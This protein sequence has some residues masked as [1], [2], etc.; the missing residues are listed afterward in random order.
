MEPYPKFRAGDKTVSFFFIRSAGAWFHALES[1]DPIFP[2]TQAVIVEIRKGLLGLFWGNPST[3]AGV[4]AC[5]DTFE[6][7]AD[8]KGNKCWDQ[9]RIHSALEVL[10]DDV[11]KQRVFYFVS[12]AL[13]NTYAWWMVHYLQ[14]SVLNATRQAARIVDIRLAEEQW[15]LEV[16]NIFN[17]SLAA[18]QL[19]AYD[20]ARGT[21]AP[22][23]NG[24][25]MIDNTPSIL[26]N[27]KSDV[28]VAV[29]ISKLFKFKN[30][31]Y[32]NISAFWFWTV[33]IGCLVI[34]LS[35]RRFSTKLTRHQ[36]TER[37]DDGGYHDCLWIT[38]FWKAICVVLVK[39]GKN[40]AIKGWN[41]AKT[42]PGWSM[43]KA[44]IFWGEV[45][46]YFPGRGHPSTPIDE[47]RGQGSAGNA[48]AEGTAFRVG[49]DEDDS[50]EG[51]EGASGNQNNITEATTDNQDEI[52]EAA[53]VNQSEIDK[54][55][56][57][58]GER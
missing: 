14:A 43:Q 39:K 33:N 34:F 40:T 28:R 51:T 52:T 41:R 25:A 7:C 42:T 47:E 53:T 44:R 29:E 3:Q 16:D 23:P 4:L 15:K 24:P 55:E 22:R 1:H 13:E 50:T 56:L 37:G 48:D 49:D 10:K 18:T 35:S 58:N 45:K 20:Y 11:D 21:Y 6:I 8:K 46:R 54:E 12:M 26:Q 9:S 19:Q 57:E 31:A 2:A 17:A 38:I 30:N 5:A 36:L 32:K 27:P